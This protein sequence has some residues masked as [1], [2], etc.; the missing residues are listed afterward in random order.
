MVLITLSSP[1]SAVTLDLNEIPL[2]IADFDGKWI[3]KPQ[4]KRVVHIVEP[5][6]SKRKV[7]YN[8]CFQIGPTK[9]MIGFAWIA[10]VSNK[11]SQCLVG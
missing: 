5:R 2:G 6:L 4:F 3:V 1:T 11:I 10:W 8:L 7:N 9:T